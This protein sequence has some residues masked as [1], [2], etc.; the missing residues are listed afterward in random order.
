MSRPNSFSDWDTRSWKSGYLWNAYLNHDSAT[1]VQPLAYYFKIWFLVLKCSSV[2]E[3]RGLS[4]GAKFDCSLL[5]TGSRCQEVG[6][7]K[8]NIFVANFCGLDIIIQN[9][10]LENN[11]IAFSC[12]VWAG[13]EPVLSQCSDC[14]SDFLSNILLRFPTGEQALDW[15]VAAVYWV[16]QPSELYDPPNRAVESF[17]DALC[18]ATCHAF[19]PVIQSVFAPIR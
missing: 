12:F 4:S 8:P 3:T 11:W 17:S 7:K 1:Q 16:S 13:R 15:L 9:L 14:E 10:L 19:C 6:L 5:T 18:D 2:Q